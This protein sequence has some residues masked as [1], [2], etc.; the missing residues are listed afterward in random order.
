MNLIIFGG[1]F[2]ALAPRDKWAHD[3][4]REKLENVTQEHPDGTQA[5]GK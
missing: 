2:Q 4:Y 3:G 5:R 1:L